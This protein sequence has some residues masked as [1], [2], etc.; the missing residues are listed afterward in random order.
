[1][2]SR[3]DLQGVVPYVEV[4]PDAL[5]LQDRAGLET[6]VATALGPLSGGRLGAEM[7]IAT[8]EAFFLEQGNVAA[9]ARR[10]GVHERTAVYRIGR[11]EALTGL[12]LDDGDDRFR[13]ELAVR[14]R[15]LL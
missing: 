4:L 7:L 2:A 14:A 6:L 15:R 1:V 10:L 9:T 11:I 13:L 3:L 8:L 5:L 12:R